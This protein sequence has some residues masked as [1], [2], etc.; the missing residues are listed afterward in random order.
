MCKNIAR[1]VHENSQ[2]INEVRG[3]MGLPLDPHRELSEFDDP[4]VEWDAADEV[5]IAAAHAPLPHADDQALSP[6][7]RAATTSS[8][9]A[10]RGQEIFD[11]DEE[12]EEEEPLNYR[13]HPDSDE[14]EDTSKDAAQDDDE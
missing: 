9:A 14:D 4:F 10:P 11:E 8:C 5:A 7:R 12:T 1:D 6:R 3:H 13:E 2:S